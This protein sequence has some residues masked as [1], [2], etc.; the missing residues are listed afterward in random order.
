[1][2]DRLHIDWT[3]CTGRA[4]CVELLPELLDRDEWGYPMAHRPG[5]ADVAVPR[6][7]AGH[8]RRA[9]R[10][11]PRLALSLLPDHR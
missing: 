2:T 5:S 4:L 9:V 3:R 1:M 6:E 11:C 10:D 8:A 7:L